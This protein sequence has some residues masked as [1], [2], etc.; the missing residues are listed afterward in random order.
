MPSYATVNSAGL[1]LIGKLYRARN[2]MHEGDIYFKDVSGNS[3]KVDL[4]MA[5]DFLAAAEQ[6]ALSINSLA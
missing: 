1:A 6:F 2:S 4:P 3:V 5:E